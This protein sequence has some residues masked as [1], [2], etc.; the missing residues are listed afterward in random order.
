LT[1]RTIWIAAAAL[2]AAGCGGDEENGTGTQ[3]RM[4]TAPK[5]EAEKP[6]ATV[7]SPG[8]APEA[9]VPRESPEDQPGG[10]GDEVPARSLAQFTGRGGR[11]TPRIVRVPPF[12]AVRAELRSADGRRYELTFTGRT[13]ATGRKISSASMV[14]DGLRPGDGY[15]GHPAPLGVNEVRIE[16]TAEPGP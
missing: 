10:A 7:T 6:R 11:I 3:A 8:P 14:L 2:A 16:A 4:E 13:I 1:R 9:T 12:I 15:V 5:T